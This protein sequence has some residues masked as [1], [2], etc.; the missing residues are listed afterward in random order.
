[1]TDLLTMLAGLRRPRLLIRAARFGA[2]D[3]RR[4][5]HLRR[6][7]RCSALP[8]TGTAILRLVEIEAALNADRLE[9]AASYS[10]AEHV[11]VLAAL[12]GEA[13]LLRALQA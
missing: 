11:E 12:M 5:R 8:R 3:Y 13:R 9:G 2:E 1:M 7:L 4:E 6:I 10:V